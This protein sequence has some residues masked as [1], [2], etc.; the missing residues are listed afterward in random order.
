MHDSYCIKGRVE[1]VLFY[2]NI[3]A[4]AC[5]SSVKASEIEVV[6]PA[7]RAE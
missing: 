3:F 7:V 5:I 4:P 2:I 1:G 6:R